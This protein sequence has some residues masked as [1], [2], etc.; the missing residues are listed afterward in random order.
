VIAATHRDLHAAVASGNFREDLLYRLR[1]VSIHLPPLRQRRDDIL[2]ICTYFLRRMGY[3]G[4]NQAI[5]PDLAAELKQR[6]WLGNVRELR[7]AILHASVIARGRPL[8]LS[9]F[10]ESRGAGE[11]KTDHPHDLLDSIV[12]SWTRQELEQGGE[13]TDLYDR[14]LAATEPALLRVILEHT[15]GNRAAAAQL[16]GM[17][18]GTLRER[19]KRYGQSGDDV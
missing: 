1:A 15:G 5:G 16:L 4:A 8:E 9:D 13:A 19:M 18:R 7:N 11:T 12:E 2:P 14:L 3:T 6:D 17:H 10:P